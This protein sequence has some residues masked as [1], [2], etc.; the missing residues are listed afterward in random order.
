[1]SRSTLTLVLLLCN[2]VV[3]SPTKSKIAIEKDLPV[4]TPYW[5]LFS[6]QCFVIKS[7]NHIPKRFS[8][9]L[10]IVVILKLAHS[11]KI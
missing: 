11:L 2:A 5:L 10:K 7:S 4:Q 3:I 1:M 6:I 8:K 9:I